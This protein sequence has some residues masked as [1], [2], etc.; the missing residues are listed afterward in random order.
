M[1]ASTLS[2]GASAHAGEPDRV[3]RHLEWLLDLLKQNGFTFDARQRTAAYRVLLAWHT[4]PGMGQLPELMAPIFARDADQ[5]KLFHELA[6]KWAVRPAS[7]TMA[8]EAPTAV[9]MRRKGG[10]A[11]WLGLVAMAILGVALAFIY[12][13]TPDSSAP[14]AGRTPVAVTPSVDPG[15]R[16]TETITLREHRLVVDMQQPSWWTWLLPILPLLLFVAWLL[17]FRILPMRHWLAEGEPD[18]T[19]PGWLPLPRMLRRRLLAGVTGGSAVSELQHGP[20]FPTGRLDTDQTVTATVREGGA[21]VPVYETRSH[22][23]EYLMLIERQGPHDHLAAMLELAVEYLRQ[24]GV[25]IDRYFYRDDP[26]LLY[27]PGDKRTWRLAEI[28]RRYRQHRLVILGTSEGYFHP[29]SGDPEPWLERLSSFSPR[30]FLNARPLGAWDWREI[31]LFEQGFSLA[32]AGSDGLDRL[33]HRLATG[34]DR[35]AALLGVR[36]RETEPDDGVEQHPPSDP[37]PRLSTEPVKL[38][39]AYAQAD[40]DAARELRRAL[41][42][43]DHERLLSIFSMED[44]EP[45]DDW[46]DRLSAE[47]AQ[48]KIVV[49]LLSPEALASRH[50]THEIQQVVNSGKR[51]IPLVLAPCDLR[52][53]PLGDRHALVLGE[54]DR[55]SEIEKAAW[56][57]RAAAIAERAV[58][59][60][61]VE[62]DWCPEMVML[63]AGNFEMGSDEYDDEKPRHT[64]RVARPFAM[65]R[66]P[67]TFDAYD[68]FCEQTGKQKPDDGGWGRGDRPVI[69][70]SW[71]DARAYA[72]W[73]S[74]VSGQSCRLP[75]EAEWEYACRA[76]TVTRYSFGDELTPEQ[77]NV[78]ESQ[79]E[80][81]TPVGQYP[82]NAFGLHDMHGNVWEWVEDHYHRSYDLAP[83]DGRAWIEEGAD[84]F[85]SRVFRGGSWFGDRDLARCAGRGHFDPGDRDDFVG[86]RVVCS[87]PISTSDP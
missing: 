50:L 54:G 12:W 26:R 7:P 57:I 59:F 86:F 11:I 32:L 37:L 67:V 74:E 17:W 55:E 69:K 78:S 47:L 20:D 13:G 23:V 60:K 68:H 16:R 25:R 73:L 6:G 65:A 27:V 41:A 63:P 84:E 31:E 33:G 2:I 36:P 30:A 85:S 24:A 62:A 34:M 45:G 1:S 18:K 48:A 9:S 29:L 51:S 64:V 10:N 46:P 81:T 87:S 28:V 38:F 39:I 79:I 53:T 43:F 8:A 70:V 61:P 75:S 82:A 40:D 52:S 72:E 35:G 42:R 21:L 4:D 76:G 19:D 56:R 15:E 22:G 3:F 49:F 83:G 71:E 58:I 80:K 66:F 77:A 5:Q 14:S 44:L